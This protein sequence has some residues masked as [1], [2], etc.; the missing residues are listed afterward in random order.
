MKPEQILF[1][2]LIYSSELP[3][4]FRTILAH[5]VAP[6]LRP[7]E[8]NPKRIR[9]VIVNRVP[10]VTFLRVPPRRW[11]IMMSAPKEMMQSKRRHVVHDCLMRLEH[12]PHDR[13]YR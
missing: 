9:L 12:Q 8:S 13:C 1:R 3:R 5:G 2:A 4:D 11:S 10:I 6:S 7:V